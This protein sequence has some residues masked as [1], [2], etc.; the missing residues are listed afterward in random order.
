MLA[1]GVARERAVYIKWGQ[2]NDLTSLLAQS[3]NNV[4]VNCKR[5][6]LEMGC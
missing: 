3:I 5:K 2:F 1:L 4:C 6:S